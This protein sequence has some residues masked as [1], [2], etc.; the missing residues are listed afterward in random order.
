MV[1]KA[2][3]RA[4]AYLQ[5]QPLCISTARD[6]NLFVVFHGGPGREINI[7]ECAYVK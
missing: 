1:A 6:S 5:F 3:N 2:A 7:I 4:A